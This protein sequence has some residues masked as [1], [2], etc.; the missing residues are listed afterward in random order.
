MIQKVNGNYIR[1]TSSGVMKLGSAP[2]FGSKAKNAE[3]DE[4][5]KEVD[6]K[7]KADKTVHGIWSNRPI[8][9]GQYI[10]RKSGNRKNIIF[11]TAI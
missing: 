7:M 3:W 5:F 9:E 10:H 6:A 8:Y 1:R 4:H 2:S 11:S